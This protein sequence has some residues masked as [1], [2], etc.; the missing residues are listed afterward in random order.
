MPCTSLLVQN[1]KEFGRIYLGEQSMKN[2][3]K[4]A[5]NYCLWGYN[6]FW[7]TVNGANGMLMKLG[8]FLSLYGAFL[9]AKN[10]GRNW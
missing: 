6:N 3:P 2:H 7:G 5:R 4:Y 8:W 9:L 1:S 10:L